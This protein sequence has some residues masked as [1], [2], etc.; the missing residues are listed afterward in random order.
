MA[1][2]KSM[3][4]I[5]DSWERRSAA[6]VQ[7]YELGIRNPRKD[8]ATETAAAEANYNKGVQAGISRKAFGKG[9]KDAGTQKWQENA[10]EKGTAR[11]SQGISAS[12]QAYIDGFTPYANVIK[13]TKLPPRGPKGD[14]GNINRVA[15]MSKALHDEKVRR[16]T[17]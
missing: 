8:W 5:T 17:A 7:D 12:K 16:T 1:D 15:V 4:R 2:I 14:P 13:N 11:W 6:S 9:V 3:D 10:I